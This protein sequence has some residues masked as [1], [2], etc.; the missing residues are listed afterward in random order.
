MARCRVQLVLL[1][2]C[3]LR[4]TADS[5]VKGGRERALVGAL[6]DN[7]LGGHGRLS[8][9]Q[10]RGVPLCMF[11]LIC[12]FTWGG[13]LEATEQV[14]HCTLCLQMLMNAVHFGPE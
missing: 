14:S 7:L 8:S 11:L 12:S 1:H 4:C 5:A 10:G 6:F 2:V 9:T 3:W 13:E